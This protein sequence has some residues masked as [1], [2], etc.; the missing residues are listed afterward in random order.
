MPSSEKAALL[1]GLLASSEPLVA[2]GIFDA[3]SARLAADAGFKALFVSG[4]A[5]SYSQLARPDIGLVTMTEL[6]GAVERISEAVDAPLL[7]DADSGF[8]AAPHVARTVRT[9]ERAGAA[10]IQIEDQL[11]V[12][13]NGAL[14]SRPVV[15][16]DEMVATIKAAC[17]A[18]LNDQ[19]VISAR[20]DAITTLG[21]EEG[22][23][24][25]Q[26][27]AEAGADMVFV[28]SLTD[29][30]DM[31]RHLAGVDGKVFTLQNILNPGAA[32][33]SAEE[34]SALGYSI[35][36]LPTVAIN[37]AAAGLREAFASYAS[38][39]Y[40]NPLAAAGGVKALIGEP[41]FLEMHKKYGV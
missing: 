28:Q 1:R 16:V 2:P 17:D 12:K 20:T 29:V 39:A 35:I 7:V 24:R 36:L 15:S 30:E 13:P 31:K 5:V 19:T 4:S 9:L 32:G 38:G 10:A 41:D 33:P 37:G 27:F 22:L 25:A 8:G 23:E 34:L 18:R 40:E 21:V 14:T 11:L 26:R 3:L 6:A